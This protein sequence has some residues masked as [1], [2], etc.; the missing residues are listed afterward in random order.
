MQPVIYFY[1]DAAGFVPNQKV[2]FTLDVSLGGYSQWLINERYVQASWIFGADERL[3]DIWV[4]KE[5]DSF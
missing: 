2:K 4:W 3:L 5:T 1:R